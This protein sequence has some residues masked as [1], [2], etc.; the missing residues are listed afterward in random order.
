MARGGAR[1]TSFKPGQSGNPGG[2]PKRPETIEARKVIAD[3]K[4]LARESTKEA[5]EALV[6]VVK[7]VKAPPSARVSAASVIL[8]RGWG[9]AT[10]VVEANV[11]IVDN[12]S[13]DELR[14]FVAR[15]AANILASE[16]ETGSSGFGAGMRGQPH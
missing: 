4:A 13:Y 5:M 12:M 7:D 10:Q 15:E 6:E 14:S 8:D 9:K 1:S 16:E 3:V 11:N 2:R